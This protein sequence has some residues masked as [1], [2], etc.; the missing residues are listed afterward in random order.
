MTKKE[1]KAVID[2][3]KTLIDEESIESNQYPEIDIGKPWEFDDPG[4]Q[5]HN[6]ICYY[7]PVGDGLY[8]PTMDLRIFA[9][10]AC[11]FLEPYHND[12]KYGEQTRLL[13]NKGFQI[14]D[15]CCA[16]KMHLKDFVTLA[17]NEADDLPPFIV[18][19][20]KR[21]FSVNCSWHPEELKKNE[22]L[23]QRYSKKD[24]E[25]TIS[26]V[27]ENLNNKAKSEEPVSEPTK[28]PEVRI[29]S[30]S[31]PLKPKSDEWLTKHYLTDFTSGVKYSIVRDNSPD[32]VNF[33]DKK[34][35]DYLLCFTKQKGLGKPLCSINK[36]QFVKY[37][38]YLYEENC[39]TFTGK[40]F[41]NWMVE[42]QIPGSSLGSI[43][44]RTTVFLKG[45]L[46]PGMDKRINDFL[47]FDI[48]ATE[49]K[50][51]PVK[52]KK[53]RTYKV[54]LDP[55]EV[56]KFLKT[57]DE[58]YFID[59]REFLRVLKDKFKCTNSSIRILFGIQLYEMYNS[60]IYPDGMFS[61]VTIQRINEFVGKN[62]AA[63]E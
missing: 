23:R 49:T 19:K 17:H 7:I 53:S 13:I 62:I 60:D 6:P 14:F 9:K 28:A 10:E 24:K 5:E 48:I 1:V 30:P 15:L 29:L 47:G 63:R 51:V 58:N 43:F 50:E 46:I 57:F 42:L 35:K 39:I 22:D 20:W 59:I 32:A 54:S 18:N 4:E 31:T 21:V 16:M 27:L 40:E 36:T 44:G 52:T 34:Y 8:R 26:K 38:Q 25:L 11:K 2:F 56:K 61:K 33:K 45:N 3:L 37:M 41:Y 55:I 12:E